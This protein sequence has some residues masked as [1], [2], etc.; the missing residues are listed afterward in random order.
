MNCDIFNMSRANTY[1]RSPRISVAEGL[2]GLAAISVAVFHFSGSL[3]SDFARL[4]GAFTWLGID[5]FFVIS[6]F[7]IPL[8]LYRRG[9]QPRDF[10]NFMLRRLLRLEPPYLVTIAMVIILGHLSVLMPGFQGGNWSYSFS[11][12][13][14]H[15]FYLVPFTDHK[16]FQPVYWSLAYECAFYVF[17]GALF[18]FLINL[19]IEWTVVVAASI[20][21]VVCLM[22]GVLDVR[23]LQF[24]VGVMLMRYFVEEDDRTYAGFWLTVAIALVFWIGGHRFG[25]KVALVAVAIMLW[26]HIEFG[27]W[28][29]FLGAISYSLFITHVPI[30]GRVINLG[31][32]FGEGAVYDFALIAFATLVSIIFAVYFSRFVERP[33]IRLSR[34]FGTRPEK[35]SPS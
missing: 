9:Y 25:V 21:A 17:I 23:I 22:K 33:A 7:V 28:A 30:G 34:R 6:G 4:I 5:V 14:S 24:I 32:R 13:A 2:R 16:W 19:R 11:Q 27:R 8:S 20:F 29:Y 12:I 18:P 15:L 10:P 31:R 3:S 35:V 26:H 1:L